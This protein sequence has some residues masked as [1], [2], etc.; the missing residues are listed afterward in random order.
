M[1]YSFAVPRFWFRL[2]ALGASLGI[3]ACARLLPTP[4]PMAKLELPLAG[5]SSRCLVV[6][7]PGRYDHPGD[8]E[9]A[10]FR[11]MARKAG[12]AADFVAVDA[13]MGY[14]VKGTIL[15]RLHADVIA[16]ARA[17]GYRTIWLAGI[18]IGGTGSI[19]YAASRPGE[20]DGLLL[21]A[22][23]LGEKPLLDEIEAAGGPARWTPPAVLDPRQDFPR[24]LWGFAHR[25][26]TA[27]R[28]QPPVYLSYGAG[29]G[30][31]RAGALFGGSLP[32]ERV[33]VAQGKHDWKAWTSGWEW[34][35]KTGALPRG[36]AAAASP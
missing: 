12:V 27:P 15:D 20:V 8:F 34:F 21:L 16:P 35:L 36:T 7:L 3:S 23:F 32:T 17:A 19:L 1:S 22:P 14:Y 4:V 31:G 18:S 29:D 10:D 25:L 26:A 6:F 30:F 5:Q 13:N 2:L 33:F 11:G 9:R 24:S 28:Q